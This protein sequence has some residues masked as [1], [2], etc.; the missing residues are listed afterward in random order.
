MND[1]EAVA[2]QLGRTPRAFR[3]V[4][5]C[6]FGL[7]AVTENLISRDMPT[8]QWVTCPRLASAISGV[9]SSGGVRA[10]Q[11]E[12]GPTAVEEIHAE[13][14]ERYGSRVAGV[15]GEGAVKCLHA[16]TAVH[17]SRAIPNAVGEWTL[18]HMSWPYEGLQRC[19][20]RIPEDKP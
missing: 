17:L 15:R 18:Q 4:F 2:L 19:C 14:V 16:F 20:T 8:S 6:P 10:A 3:V 5:R 9:E 1:H 7:P 13:H 12:V 11:E